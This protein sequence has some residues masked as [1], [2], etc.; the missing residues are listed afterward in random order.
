MNSG[1]VT[2]LYLWVARFAQFCLDWVHSTLSQSVLTRSQQDV[3]WI[4]EISGRVE[5]RRYAPVGRILMP[6]RFECFLRAGA[7]KGCFLSI[8]ILLAGATLVCRSICFSS[9]SWCSQPAD[10]IMQRV[11]VMDCVLLPYDQ[12]FW[13]KCF[14]C[15][16]LSTDGTQNADY[17]PWCRS[18]FPAA[19]HL[20]PLL[21]SCCSVSF[22]Q[23]NVTGEQNP[24][25]VYICQQNN[26]IG[27]TI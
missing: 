25:S 24:G 26:V 2:Q 12:T 20:D 17:G 10:K 18:V 11:L 5:T 6:W 27:K 21:V 23:K 7:L 19:V 16:N 4:K 15:L 9:A 1:R 13:S 8:K 14:C 22:N 3:C